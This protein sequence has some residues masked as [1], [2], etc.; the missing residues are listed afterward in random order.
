[1]QEDGTRGL[2]RRPVHM[3]GE[4]AQLGVLQPGNG[5]RAE[6]LECGTARPTRLRMSPPEG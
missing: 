4:P 2:L 1:M 3:Y 5:L 6:L